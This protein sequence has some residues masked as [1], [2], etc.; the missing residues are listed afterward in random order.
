M[1][2]VDILLYVSLCI[3]K[4]EKK[5]KIG[6]CSFYAISFYHNLHKSHPSCLNSEQTIFPPVIPDRRGSAV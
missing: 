6:V 4:I 2:S 3:F 5:K 1:F